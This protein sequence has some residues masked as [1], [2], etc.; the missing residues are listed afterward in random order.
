M[1]PCRGAKYFVYRE[2]ILNTGNGS[3]EDCLSTRPS[4]RR[5]TVKLKTHSGAKKRFRTT[6]GGK[7]KRKQQ[8]L[9]HILVN[10]SS[11][12]K[13]HLGKMEYVD[14]AN[15]YQVTRQLAGDM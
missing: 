9:R 11:K 6:G 5:K 1:S 3:K 10:K 4:R 8:G 15:M 2:I 13:R 7:V 14:S 12:R